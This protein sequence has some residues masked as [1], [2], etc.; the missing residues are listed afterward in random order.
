MYY[1]VNLRLKLIVENI[2]GVF[3]SFFWRILLRMCLNDS[4]T[5][6]PRDCRFESHRRLKFLFFNFMKT[7]RYLRSL[8]PILLKDK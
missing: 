4:V 5:S 7:L 1:G 3:G 6:I 2:K 8:T